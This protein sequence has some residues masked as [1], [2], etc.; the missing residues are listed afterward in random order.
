MITSGARAR[1]RGL[2]RRPHHEPMARFVE[3]GNHRCRQMAEKKNS[4]IHGSR[5]TWSTYTAR[6]SGPIPGAI[7]ASA[8]SQSTW[9]PGQ[10]RAIACSSARPVALWPSAQPP[11]GRA[12]ALAER[13]PRPQ[14]APGGR[15]QPPV[16]LGL[17]LL[18]PEAGA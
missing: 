15:L 14:Q 11:M 8:S 7:E 3:S 17:E 12:L 4:Y 1:I 5:C 9:Q 6:A 18:S 10:V 13:V 16:G 2:I